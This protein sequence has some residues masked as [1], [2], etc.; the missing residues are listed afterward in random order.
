MD[1][2]LT[3]EQV[4]IQQLAREFAEKE[5]KPI[6]AEIDEEERYPEETIPKMFKAGFF[7]CPHPKALGGAGGDYVAYSICMEEIAK[8]CAS[9][10]VTLYI[11]VQKLST[12]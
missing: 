8:V 3:K 11:I 1:F 6:A 9:T 10:A 4:L 2:T 12:I 7:Q 5:V